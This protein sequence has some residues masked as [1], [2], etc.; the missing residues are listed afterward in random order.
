M[1]SREIV[2]F[3]W[4]AGDFADALIQQVSPEPGYEA[5]V[6]TS[7]P[8]Q[9]GFPAT[10]LIPSWTATTPGGSFVR[11]EL[12]GVNEVGRTTKWFRLGD[13][14]AEETA[15]TRTSVS[16]QAD[17]DAAVNADVLVVSGGRALRSV[18][19]RVTLLWPLGSTDRP[20]LRSLHV[21]A[22]AAEGE[23]V[24]SRP[25]AAQGRLLA[26]P[27]YSQLIHEGGQGWCSAAS[28]AMVLSY[29]GVGPLPESNPD[30][31]VPYTA[32]KIFDQGFGGCGNWPFNTAY[33]GGFGVRSFVTRLRSLNEAELF[34][35]AGIPLVVSAS[36]GRGQV[37]GL[38]YDTDGHLTVLVGFTDQGDPVLNDPN[39]ASNAEVQKAVG[40]AE[41][42][43]AW[44]RSSRGVVYV[45]H[46][47]SVTLPPS[48][49]QANW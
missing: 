12:R 47:E 20:E 49:A 30:S 48:P 36:Y 28:T 1:R 31:W 5:A 40:R 25:L 2:L 43:M 38:D 19:A 18:Q 15:F 33:A 23:C 9:P 11:V 21:L 3:R 8:M 44:L 46:P 42:E 34:I 41:W 22:S 14:A 7:E 6:W 17:E 37:P 45:I 24:P 26:V 32:K 10:E 29:W 13:W 35:E 39:S 16:G 27:G 4:G